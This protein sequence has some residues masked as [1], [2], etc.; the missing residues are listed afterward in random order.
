MAAAQD[1]NKK[2]EIEIFVINKV[3]EFREAAKLSKRKLSLELRLNH[4][5]V[6]NVENPKS[7]AKYNL[8]Q[9][10]ELAKIFKCTIADFI[11]SPY[12][13]TDTIEEYMELHPKIKA[14]YEIMAKNYE[15]KERKKIEEKERK[16][17]EKA[18]MKKKATSKKK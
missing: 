14:K 16:K 12:I 1:K 9:L 8:N 4:N 3:K 5:Y 18:A 7:S 10:N 2:T 17:K 15:E 13:K 11:P 6:N